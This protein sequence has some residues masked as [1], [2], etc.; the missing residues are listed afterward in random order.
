MQR[1][2]ELLCLPDQIP[3]HI[4]VDISPLKIGDIYH[5]SHIKFPQGVKPTSSL[6]LP[7]CGVK[8]PRKVA[9]TETTKKPEAK[10]SQ[11]KSTSADTD[12]TDKKGAEK[13]SAKTSKK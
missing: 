5:I 4:E 3:Q 2:I 6:D 1:D 11:S 7:I 10:D 12:K 8:K 13:A 9:A